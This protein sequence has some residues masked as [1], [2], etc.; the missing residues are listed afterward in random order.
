MPLYAASQ[1]TTTLTPSNTCNSSTVVSAIASTL[2]LAANPSRLFAS[3]TNNTNKTLYLDFD[4]AA[5]VTD[6][7]V[8]VPQ[9]TLYEL[10]LNFTGAI[11]GIW[12]GVDTGKGA[13]VREFV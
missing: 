7:A 9:G 6:Y 13:L 12:S 5:S 1:V 10:P 8:A 4:G 11:H 2:I 3:V